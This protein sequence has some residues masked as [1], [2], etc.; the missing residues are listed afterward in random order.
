M[1]Y[2]W[3][4]T[5]WADENALEKQMI[6]PRLALALVQSLLSV[7]TKHDICILADR[8]C[9]DLIL[10][11]ISR[12]TCIP[13]ANSMVNVI[14]YDET[15]KIR[16]HRF[17]WLPTFT[18]KEY[19]TNRFNKNICSKAVAFKLVKYEKIVMMDADCI[20]QHN[21]DELFETSA[22]AATFANHYSR[23]PAV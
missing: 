17:N 8:I 15:D 19:Y 11:H 21:C 5:V 12:L 10:S 22:P 2:S 18:Q 7:E 13:N 6:Y 23:T 20:V 16:L 14:L 1:P 3:V 4:I 9:Y